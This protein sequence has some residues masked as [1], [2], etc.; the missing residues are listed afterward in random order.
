M[1]LLDAVLVFAVG[2]V[3]GTV[4]RLFAGIAAV[5]ALVLVVL[6]I[7]LPAD[8]VAIADPVVEVY[9]GNGSLRSPLSF[10]TWPARPTEPER[11]EG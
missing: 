9:R 6:G 10:R 3:T 4:T 8:V 5:G 11:S 1:G 7:A 2:Y